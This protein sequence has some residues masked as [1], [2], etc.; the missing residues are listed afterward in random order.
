MYKYTHTRTYTHNEDVSLLQKP[1]PSLLFVFSFCLWYFGH[2]G[3]MSFYVVKLIFLCFFWFLPLFRCFSIFL[4]WLV[5]VFDNEQKSYIILCEH[6]LK[7]TYCS[8]M[9]FI[10]VFIFYKRTFYSDLEETSVNEN[11]LRHQS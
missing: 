2:K 5:F 11:F 4:R 3:L 6:G 1:F 7:C 9:L 10:S 8:Q